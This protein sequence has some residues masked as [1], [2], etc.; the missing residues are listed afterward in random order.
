[1]NPMKGSHL[2][3]SR[4]MPWA[5]LFAALLLAASVPAAFA[6]Q[7]SAGAPTADLVAGMVAFDKAWIPVLA[8]SNQDKPAAAR[9]A[10]AVL[11]AQ[12][13][14]F[15]RSFGARF[16]EADW[17]QG[18]ERTGAVLANASA[19]LSKGD[20]PGAH[21]ALEEVRDT[22]V[23]LRE[24][25][26]IPYY[27]DYL[28]RYHESMEAVTAVTAGRTPATLGDE[29]IVQVRALLPE[30]RKR[31]EATVSA[32]F[33]AAAYGFSAAKAESL[34]AA[35]QAVLQGIARVE[36]ALQKADREAI[37][38]AVEA[39]KPAFTKTFLLFGNFEGLAG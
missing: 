22:W 6:Q 10:M 28:N 20:L 25:R 32:S 13:A 33:D 37:I 5:I 39:M 18:V 14:A 36:Q 1:M 19:L 7:A 24:S 12:W 9:K 8:L 30:A 27:V 17:A 29:Q 38:L 3:G 11:D 23:R 16:P 21:A 2:I 31:W 15:Y 35:E 34:R 4:R 26:S